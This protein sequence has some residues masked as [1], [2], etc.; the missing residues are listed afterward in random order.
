[1]RLALVIVALGVAVVAAS[2]AHAADLWKATMVPGADAGTTARIGATWMPG[3]QV[4][5]SCPNNQVTYRMCPAAD[6]GGCTAQS[7]DAPIAANSQVDLCFPTG[8]TALSLYKQYD[9]GNPSCG[10]YLVTPKT[11]CQTP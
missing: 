8:Y 4:M 3:N 10:V 2:R 11:V 1:M 6:A 5:V 9:G 7:Y